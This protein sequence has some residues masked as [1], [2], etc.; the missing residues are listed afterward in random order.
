VATGSASAALPIIEAIGTAVEST[1]DALD[2]SV[3]KLSAAIDDMKRFMPEMENWANNFNNVSAIFATASDKFVRPADALARVMDKLGATIAAFSEGIDISD[4]VMSIAGIMIHSAELFES[5]AERIQI[6]VNAK[7]IPAMRAAEQAGIAEAVRSQ[8]VAT[9]RVMKDEGGATFEL[10]DEVEIANRTLGELIKLNESVSAMGNV[11]EGGP[12][13]EIV[14]LLQ[15]FLPN[16]NRQTN[17]LTSNMNGW[18]K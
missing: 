3:S 10:S 5:A 14:S 1:A 15:T 2:R 8:A 16:L 18:N 17:G 6:A 7:A 11:G 9:V 4:K 13:T 12:I